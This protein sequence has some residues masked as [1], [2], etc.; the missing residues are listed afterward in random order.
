MAQ[1]TAGDIINEG[2]LLAG[3]D[4]I[5]DRALT[6]LQAWLD[7]VANSWPWPMNTRE[8]TNI[9]L[10]A[11]TTTLSVGNGDNGVTNK[12]LRVFDNVWCYTSDYTQRQ[13]LRLK[14]YVTMPEAVYNPNTST[15]QPSEIRI[16]QPTGAGKFSLTFFPIPDKAYLLTLDYLELPA[17]LASDASVPWYPNDLT[18][19]QYIAAR[20]ML[21]DNGPDGAYQAAIAETGDM[22]K[23]DR[24]RFG[25]NPGTN[26]QIQLDSTS[27]P[28]SAPGWRWIGW[29]R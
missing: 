24:L 28:T 29:P 21:Y 8:K 3:R 7:S 9:A 22:L 13:Q 20:T 25:S 4:D 12:I 10:P 27:F 16:S 6:W 14:Q 26:D 5:A 17:A 2:M 23:A 11:G 19:I 18:M 1:M 15:G